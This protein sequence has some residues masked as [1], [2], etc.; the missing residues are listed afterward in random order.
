M[1]SAGQKDTSVR[2]HHQ[3]LPVAARVTRL[4]ALL[5]GVPR[6][7]PQLCSPDVAAAA[8]APADSENATIEE[9]GRRQELSSELELG[10]SFPAIAR[11]VPP[12][13]RR[14]RLALL[15]ET[16]EDEDT[17]RGMCEGRMA[18]AASLRAVD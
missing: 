6:G 1:T 9:H 13:G 14:E 15:V 11:G 7:V 16:S 17:P 3:V 12:F 4:G 10:P 8:G 18:G 2:E 5:E